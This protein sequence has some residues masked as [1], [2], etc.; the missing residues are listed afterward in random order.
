M[1][2]LRLFSKVQELSSNEIRTINGGFV[3]GGLC[4]GGIAF[5]VG[6]AVGIIASEMAHHHS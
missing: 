2:N 5:L 6:A 3:C 4:I 1:K